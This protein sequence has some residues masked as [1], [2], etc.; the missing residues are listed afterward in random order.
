MSAVLA[1]IIFVVLTGLI[2]LFIRDGK[3]CTRFGA[4][5]IVTGFIPVV[6][7][8]V[9]VLISGTA[10]SLK[11]PWQVPYGSFYVEMDSLSAL[12]LLAI[13]VSCSTAAIYGCGYMISYKDRRLGLPTFFFNMLAAGMAMVVMA[14]NGVLFLV[15]W[16]IMSLASYFL[17]TFEDE[18]ESVRQ[19]G[20]IY[21]VATH[22]GTAFLL[23]FFVIVGQY[24]GTMDFDRI[25]VFGKASSVLFLLA[26][27]GFGTKAGIMPLHVWLPE[28]HPAAPS[29]VSAVMSG[30]MIKMGIYGII[31]TISIM[32]A[33]ELWW[34]WL[35]IWLGIISGIL[36]ILFAIA[37]HDIKRML[38]YSSVENIGII[39]IGLGL[40]VIGIASNSNVLVIF[41]FAGTLLH[42]INHSLFK[43]LLFMGAGAVVHSSGTRRMDLLGGLIN[44]MPKTAMAFVIGAAAICGLPPLNG[45]IGEFLLYYG[46]LAAILSDGV[47]MAVPTIM[48]IASLALIGGLAMA[49]FTKVFGIVF[50]GQARTAEAA[51]AHEARAE[52]T[53]AMWIL[54]GLCAAV[55]ITAPL[56]LPVIVRIVLQ[57]TPAVSGNISAAV[58][59]ADSILW[60]IVIASL[61]FVVLAVILAKFR[62]KLLRNKTVTQSVTWDCGYAAPTSRIQYTASSFSQPIVSMFRDI[63]AWQSKTKRITELF[64]K[65]AEFESHTPDISSEYIYRPVF[66]WIDKFMGRMQWLQY[67]VVQVYVLYI[68]ITLLI[69]LMWKL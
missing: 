58:N 21:I 8:A 51:N 56:I 10:I 41:G 57:I 52:M 7:V 6:A 44:G 14:R 17:V 38:A 12:F 26:L 59:L 62:Q 35:L 47:P 18:R 63:L 19:A 45:F 1:G 32:P 28:A 16:E 53:A 5:G 66:I 48:A 30:V 64:P 54:A 11:I 34:G 4:T 37:Q 24:N 40:G 36:G 13:A 25:G 61:S 9:N 15:A 2:S 42:T 68:A 69:L 60:P 23:A 39:L 31:R 20:W 33:V 65:Q 43:S 67:G 50:L 22:I 3:N 49:G 29:H 55:G 27:V 46:S